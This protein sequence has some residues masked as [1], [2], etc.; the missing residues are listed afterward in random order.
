M[1]DALRPA[2]GGKLMDSEGRVGQEAV[3]NQIADW[4]D[5]SGPAVG[6]Q[7]SR[8]NRDSTRL[9]RRY[10]MVLFRLRDD[11]G[12]PIYEREGDFESRG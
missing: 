9:C 8:H 3:C 11:A 7:K 12:E 2:N 6:D 4:V 10:R 5:M 1:A